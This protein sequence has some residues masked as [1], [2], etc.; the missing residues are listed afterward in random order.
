MKANRWFLAG[1]LF[2][3]VALPFS[4]AFAGTTGKITGRVTDAAGSPLP[5]ASVVIE[6]TQRGAITDAEGFYLILL[7]DPGAY[8]LSASLV[9]YANV[10]KQDVRVTVDYTS[11]VNFELRE[12]AIEAA[13][14]VVTAER[15]PVEL[16][17]TTTKYIV[18]AEDIEQTPIIKTTGEFIKLQPG[19]DMAGSFSVRGTNVGYAGNFRVQGSPSYRVNAVNVVID[20]VRISGLDGAAAALFTGV[21]KSAVQQI[22][23]ETGVTPAE[24]GDARAGTINIVTKDGGKQFHG[25]TEVILETAGK[26]HWGANIYDAPEHRDHMKWDDPEWLK[27]T[28]PLTGRIIYVREDYTSYNGIGLEG[29]LSGPVGSRASFVASLKHDRRAPIFPDATNH[30][31][32]NDTG[33]YVNA[34]NNIQGSGSIT[35]K[36]TGSTKFKAGLILQRYTA[37]NN[38][39]NFRFRGVNGFIRG[40]H[41]RA[42]LRNLFLPK[43]W[44]ASGKYNYQ[45]DL[46]YLTLAHAISPKTFYEVR[47]ARSHTHQDTVGAPTFT[48]KPRTDRSGWFYIDG[49][50]ATWAQSRRTRWSLKADLSSQ[51]TK[52]NFVKTGFEI[53]RFNVYYTQWAALSK[54]NNMFSFYA[55]GDEPW[56]M[57][58]PATP[59]R[60]GVYVQDKMEFEGMIVNVGVRLDFQKHTH[61][62]LV[63]AALMPMP[64]WAYYNTR[65][66]AYASRF[67]KT[68]P[69]EFHL[70]PRLGVSHPLTDRM[71]LHFSLGKFVQWVDFYALYAKT[72]YNAGKLGPDGDPNWFDVNGNGVR[73]PAETYASMVPANSGVSADPHDARAE[74][75][76]TFEVGTDWNFV[77]DYTASVTMFYR[78]DTNNYAPQLAGYVGRSIG[79][80]GRGAASDYAAFNKGFEVSVGKRLSH[81]FGFRVGWYLQWG[82]NGWMGLANSLS[83]TFADS[84]FVSGPDYFE[85]W[86]PNPDGSRSPVAM[87]QEDIEKTGRS[88]NQRARAW[89]AQYENDHL[90]YF[91]KHAELK[92]E[93][94][95]RALLPWPGNPVMVAYGSTGARLDSQTNLQ[96]ILNTPSDV[97]FGPRFL[98]WLASDLN[99]NMLWKLRSG[100]RARWVPPGSTFQGRR[101]DRGAV[102]AATDLSAEKVFNAKGRV[103]PSF[104]IE[105]RNLFNDKIDRSGGANY[106]RWGLQMAPP[107]NKDFKQYGDTGDRS[108]YRA[109]RQTNLG[110]RVVF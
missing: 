49:Q 32:Y 85:A 106:M 28:D 99:A 4:S 24:Y 60:G 56:R 34:P 14:I 1:V 105:V 47:I 29:T 33:H 88:N 20:G 101:L 64:M 2:L 93:A 43:E 15:P 40:R 55:G 84:N 44:A 25:W 110:I 69:M 61:K 17:K 83:R 77:S 66:N 27:E 42:G 13:E 100:D 11:T 30:G 19:V 41:G 79:R 87:S 104:F 31:F 21:N 23:I 58:S 97:R 57:G 78:S 53:I 108:Y 3:V 81:Y 7:V 71:K 95:Y 36:P 5:G 109:P 63:S 92:D 86:Q 80:S 65:Q 6:D 39:V 9:G 59:I 48:D 72:Y 54:T 8:D 68:P 70:S 98:G 73:D 107:D 45:E 96:F 12:E 16:D 76:L 74:Q 103:R 82:A 52:R 62:E 10:T 18:S 26:K 50:V 89:S 91:G 102:D 90:T 46:E 94:F 37:F 75:A 22:S 35:F 51:L 38:E 67:A